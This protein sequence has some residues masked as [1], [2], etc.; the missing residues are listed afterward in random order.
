MKDSRFNTCL[1]QY[2]KQNEEEALTHQILFVSMLCPFHI[3]NNNVIL[4]AKL[5]IQLMCIL[6]NVR[7]CVSVCQCVSACVSS[8]TPKSW[9]L[10]PWNIACM[11]RELQG[12]AW[13]KIGCLGFIK[14]PLLKIKL[15]ALLNYILYQV[16]PQT[17][18]SRWVLKTHPRLPRWSLNL[19]FCLACSTIP[20]VGTGL[21]GLLMKKGINIII[22]INI[23]I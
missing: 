23:S 6:I 3:K 5:C 18:R 1:S 20:W 10:A 17:P 13:V 8:I 12:R 22:Y 7:V 11:P 9:N 21:N 14:T 15:T 16:H 2:P 4:E 19:P